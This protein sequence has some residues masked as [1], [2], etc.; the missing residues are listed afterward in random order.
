LN[1]VRITKSP[2]IIGVGW[3]IGFDAEDSAD[4]AGEIVGD[5]RLKVYPGLQV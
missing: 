5:T 4:R 1:R 3:T 2:I